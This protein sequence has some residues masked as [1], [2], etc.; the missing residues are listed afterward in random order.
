MDGGAPLIEVEFFFLSESLTKLLPKNYTTNIEHNF[1]RDYWL[2]FITLKSFQTLKKDD[3]KLF[4]P[5]LV[6]LSQLEAQH[7]LIR[8]QL[9]APH[10]TRWAPAAAGPI[11]SRTFH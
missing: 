5:F 6:E 3:K 10:W 11:A 4:Y 9:L 2:L 7:R 8:S 1:N